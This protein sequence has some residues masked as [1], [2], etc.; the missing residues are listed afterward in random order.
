MVKTDTHLMLIKDRY[1]GR[2]Q[3]EVIQIGGDAKNDILQKPCHRIWYDFQSA[4]RVNS[5]ELFL[6][7]AYC[8]KMI[9]VCSLP[10]DLHTI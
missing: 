9:S 8:F 10:Q 6:K 3:K 5:F 2:M 1:Y 7:L 4:K